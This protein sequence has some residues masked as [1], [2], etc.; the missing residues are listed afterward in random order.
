MELDKL[1]AELTELRKTL[2]GNT[3]V[4]VCFS[5]PNEAWE[6][7]VSDVFTLKYGGGQPDTVGIEAEFCEPDEND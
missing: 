5:T 4:K 2:P 3:T 6:E 1:I 7:D